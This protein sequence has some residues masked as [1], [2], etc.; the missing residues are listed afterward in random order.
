MFYMENPPTQTPVDPKNATPGGNNQSTTKQSILKNRKA[1]I[2]IAVVVVLLIA[3]FLLSRSYGP[4]SDKSQMPGSGSGDDLNKAPGANYSAEKPKTAIAKVGEEYI[5]QEDLEVELANYSGNKDENVKKIL[6]DKL[7]KD[8]IILQAAKKEN[9]ATVSGE[10]FNSNLKNYGKRFGELKAVEEKFYNNIPR[11]SGTIVTVWF[12]NMYPAKIGL[13]AGKAE[14]LKRITALHRRVKNGEI[15]IEQAG[16]LIKK[17][18]SYDNLDFGYTVNALYSFTEPKGD[19]ITF[20]DGYNEIL[21]KTNPGEI[22]DVYLARTINEFSGVND[23]A[24]YIFGQV[25]EKTDGNGQGFPEWYEKQKGNY[26]V[27]YY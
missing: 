17:D 27:T 19:R 2:I 14:A 3:L 18:P 26:E 12:Y 15:T 1:L 20:D 6:V 24:F 5:F 25:T 13:E 4:L 11:I 22:T 23:E 16:D 10:I 21:W 7:V 8:S 9:L